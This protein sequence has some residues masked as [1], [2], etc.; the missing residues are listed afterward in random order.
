MGLDHGACDRK[1]E[2]EPAIVVHAAGRIQTTSYDPS[3]QTA[4][5]TSSLVVN[6]QS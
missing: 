1:T 4:D 3:G 5:T 2:T 6:Y